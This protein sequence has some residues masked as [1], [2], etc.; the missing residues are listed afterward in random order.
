[1]PSPL[2][3]S[4]GV[5]LV[6]ASALFLLLLLNLVLIGRQ[7]RLKR[8]EVERRLRGV[9][10]QIQGEARQ[11]VDL[12]RGRCWN[13]WCGLTQA[14]WGSKE[15]RPGSRGACWIQLVCAGLWVRLCLSFHLHQ[16]PSGMARRS[17]GQMQLLS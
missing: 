11:G 2:A 4:H 14:F 3:A 10:D 9:I 1:M 16:M 15:S 12:Q 17:S 13:E 8:R 5:E 7:D 6:N